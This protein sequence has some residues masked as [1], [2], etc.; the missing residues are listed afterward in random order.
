[1]TLFGIRDAHCMDVCWECPL[2]CAQCPYMC[3]SPPEFDWNRRLCRHV[4]QPT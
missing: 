4:N 2:Q 1:V 3:I